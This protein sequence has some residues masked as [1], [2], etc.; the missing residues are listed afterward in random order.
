MSE[1]FV[2]VYSS[3]LC[4]CSVCV[5]SEMPVEEIERQT[6]VKYPTGIAGQWKVST[7]KTFRD[8]AANPH[9]CE[10]DHTRLHYL[11]DC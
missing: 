4:C 3:G 11:L 10:A 8:G 2:M 6:N 9:P 5:P 1:P 7:D